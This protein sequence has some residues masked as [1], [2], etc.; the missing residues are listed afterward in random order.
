MHDCVKWIS[1]GQQAMKQAQEWQ[2]V[3]GLAQPSEKYTP[4]TVVC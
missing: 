2:T 3:M 4:Y 1:T